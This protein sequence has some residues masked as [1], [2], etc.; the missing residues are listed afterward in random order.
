MMEPTVAELLRARLLFADAQ[1]F[2]RFSKLALHKI[3]PVGLKTKPE[4]PLSMQWSQSGIAMGRGP[5]V[6]RCSTSHRQRRASHLLPFPGRCLHR[7][8]QWR[9]LERD[10]DIGA[11]LAV[12][13]DGS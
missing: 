11:V 8:R 6:V 1:I 4:R 7:W 5:C 12:S 2:G 13:K 9:D 10:V 3:G